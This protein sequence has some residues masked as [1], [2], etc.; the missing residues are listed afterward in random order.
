VNDMVIDEQAFT[1]QVTVKVA[2]L[3]GEPSS[4]EAL[5]EDIRVKLQELETP[6]IH[7][8]DN[9]YEITKVTAL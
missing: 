3:Y 8:D 5:R 7:P 1:F 4:R 9:E 6:D 2:L